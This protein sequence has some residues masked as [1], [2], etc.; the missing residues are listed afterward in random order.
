MGEV[1]VFS[2]IEALPRR[3]E[4]AMGFKKSCFCQRLFK[5]ILEL[6]KMEEY[7]PKFPPYLQSSTG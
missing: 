4:L 3:K 5:A 6:C 1:L 2:A 7:H